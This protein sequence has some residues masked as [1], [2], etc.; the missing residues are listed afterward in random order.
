L[1]EVVERRKKM[2]KITKIVFIVVFILGLGLL[3]VHGDTWGGPKLRCSIISDIVSIDPAHLRLAQDRMVGQ[4]VFQG[5]VTFDLTVD[6][7][8]PVIPALAESYEVSKDAKMITFRL[9]KGVQFHRGY[10]ELT[11]E[12]V[13]F[14]LQR[15]L[16][17]KV[18]SRARAQLKDIER[19]EAPDKYT[20][21]VYM[22]IPSA[23]SLIQNLAWQNAGFIMSKKACTKLG[24][25]I[26]TMPIGTGPYYFDRWEPGEKV[27]LKKFD[28]YWRTPA[29]IDEIEFWE[30]WVIP[31]ET[32]ALGA[33]EKG[34]LDL[35]P[36]TQQGS[37][38]RAKAMKGV[39]IARAKGG[40]ARN[41]VYYLNHKMKPLGDIRVRK[42][43][44]HALDLKE[45]ASRI[46]GLRIFPSPMSPVVF[47]AT[48][49]F[50]QYEYDLDKA[51]KLLA[52]AGYPKGFELRLI[53][54]KADLYE[55]V[56]L[57]VQQY[58]NKIVDV[59]L[60]LIERAVY[61]KTLRKYKH[62][63]ASW[64]R[65][66]YAPFLYAQCYLTGASVNYSNYS[67]P[68]VDEVIKKAQTA[69]TEEE[70]RKYWREFQKMVT[71]DVVNLWLGNQEALMAISNKVKDV[72]VMPSPGVAFLERARIE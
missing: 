9:K 65:T 1:K 10:G 47:G 72:I 37:Y 41:Y 22:K 39:Y 61:S 46:T 25:K 15:H 71:E 50:W 69:M 38:D 49:E 23:Y 30:F 4:Q 45:I 55:P 2:V 11:S 28:K 6:P 31:E 59:K 34:D 8:Y 64:G 19:V 52:E 58:W 12:D 14:T 33:L 24:D 54:N 29:R 32:V 20:V 51:R 66:R 21:K 63:V 7:P 43:L 53:Y 60:E 16:D 18:A 48:D 44:A 17:K 62:D 36:L 5:L 68:K 3:L 26:P 35:V 57:E 42:A 13:V 67:N 56:A 40:G 70:S 27:V